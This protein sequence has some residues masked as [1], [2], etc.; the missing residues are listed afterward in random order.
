MPEQMG[1]CTECGNEFTADW[2]DIEN[3]ICTAC[4]ERIPSHDVQK[5]FS[6]EEPDQLLINQGCAMPQVVKSYWKKVEWLDAVEKIARERKHPGPLA[7]DLVPA[8]EDARPEMLLEVEA[9]A[10]L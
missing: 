7:I 5:L 4:L 8:D 10:Y 6:M 2:G 3:D 9:T 1:T